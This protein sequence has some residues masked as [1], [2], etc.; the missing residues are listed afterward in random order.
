MVKIDRAIILAAGR[1]SRL[2][3]FTE[4]LPKT[5][6]RIGDL[7]IF[8]RIV[9]GLDRIGIKEIV[10]VIG[11][12]GSRLKT[13]TTTISQ[14]L[15]Q[16]R[17]D[18]EFIDND[19]LAIGNIYSFW[20]AKGKIDRDFILVNSDVVFH[21]GVLDLLSA[22]PHGTSLLVDDFKKLGE[23]EM[24]VKVNANGFVKEMTKEID[25]STANG[26]YI[27]IMKVSKSVA[28]IVLSKVEML[29]AKEE[30]PLYYE[31][32]FKLVAREQDCLYACSTR[33]LPWAEVDTIEDMHKATNTILPQIP[34]SV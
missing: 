26:E 16:N 6:L 27:G 23:E 2:G 32:A 28:D 31:D 19:N 3:S 30:Y 15:I 34:T 7:T 1:G 14:K 5:M 4:G 18:F 13:H 21:H 10:V 22:S 33:A 25:P 17:V 8:D 9:M 24:K 12:A 20:R 11:Y 29:L